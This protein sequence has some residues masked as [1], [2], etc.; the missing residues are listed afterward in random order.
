M[1]GG[2][3]RPCDVEEILPTKKG[4]MIFEILFIL[5]FLFFTALFFYKQ[6]LEDFDIVQIE[7]AQVEKVPALLAENSFLVIRSLPVLTLWTPAS[8]LPQVLATPYGRDTLGGVV[9][10]SAVPLQ[11]PLSGEDLARQTGV[12]TWMESTWFPRLIPN[13]FLRP[14]YT[15]RCEAAVG[16]K[17]LRKSYAVTTLLFATEGELRVSVMPESVQ[18]YLPATWEGRSFASLQRTDAPLLGEVK[19]LDIR[20][21]PGMVL[22]IPPHWILNL[23]QE[24]AVLPWFLWVEIHHPISKIAANA[25]RHKN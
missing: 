2:R 9:A 24:G 23:A 21:R 22:C 17:G 25:A 11:F 18:T 14:L 20:L 3:L 19:F 16:E 13:S 15:L 8:V 12:H 4:R 6:A 5:V 1:G 10:G 7:A